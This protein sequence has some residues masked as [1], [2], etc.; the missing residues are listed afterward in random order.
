MTRPPFRWITGLAFAGAVAAVFLV[1]AGWISVAAS[2]GHWRWTSWLLHYAMRQSVAFQADAEPPVDLH[3]PARIRLGAAHF[4]TGC[5]VCHGSP[6]HPRA[7]M[8]AHMTPEPPP[9]A[10]RVGDWTDAELQWIV[11]HGVK[12]TGMPAWPAQSRPDEAW[13]MAAF[14]RALPDMD[15]ATYRALALGELATAGSDLSVDPDGAPIADCRRCHGSDGRGDPNGAFPRLDILGERA[16][17]TA[18]TAYAAGARASG[19]MRNAA[20]D[21]AP[22]TLARLAARYG[23]VPPAPIPGRRT[24][25]DP[26][27]LARGE[28]IA[29]KGVPERDVAACS[30]CHDDGDGDP[31]PALKGQYDRYLRTQLELFAS[32]ADRGGGPFANLMSRST[33]ALAP[34]EIEAVAAWYASFTPGDGGSPSAGEKSA[35]P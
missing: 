8:M 1:W 10:G 28:T 33:H 27:L 34:D 24:A 23:A 31:F 6:A 26:D 9:L 18:L 17:L 3:D 30:G 4:E 11:L 13:S 29:A 12:F 35:A 25:F 7:P 20:R 21:L 15:A 22:E 2:S 14:L 5:A 32:G 19:V 16:I